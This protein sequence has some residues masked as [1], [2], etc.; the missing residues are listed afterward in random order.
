[1]GTGK[2]AN[3]K[4]SVRKAAFAHKA[5]GGAGHP[6]NKGPKKTRKR[7]DKQMNKARDLDKK[8]FE[9]DK[10]EANKGARLRRRAGRVRTRAGS[11][12][13]VVEGPGKKGDIKIDKKNQGKFTAW[14]K[15]NMPS[16][17][18]CGAAKAVM[19]NKKKYTTRVVKMANFA[20]N[21]ACKK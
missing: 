12:N 17:D 14:A 16:K 6:D 18:T 4:P 10:E 7:Y 19:K 9:K 20:K 21:F 5:D 8:S 1:M 15:K 11:I 3:A 2:L 13:D